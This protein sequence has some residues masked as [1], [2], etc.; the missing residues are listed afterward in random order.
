MKQNTKIG[1]ILVTGGAGFVGSHLI[2]KLLNETNTSMIYIIDN[3]VRTN[4]LRNIQHLLDDPK[5][6][7]RLKFINADVSTF[8]F[9]SVIDPFQIS[10]VFHLSATRI[11]R[12][13]EFNA[14]GHKYIADAGFNL[15]NWISKYS[16]IKL[17]FASSASVYQSP[18]RFPIEETD[19]CNP[20]TIY[21]AGKFY[22]EN[23]IKS[24]NLLYGMDYT[25]N[26]FFSV[27]GPRMDNIGPYTEVIFNWLNSVKKGNTTITVNGDPE[28]K[29][30]DL[31][32]IDDVID[33]IMLS[34]FNSN[35]STFNVSSE[36]GVSLMSLINTIQNVTGKNLK[37]NIVP[38]TRKDIELKRVGSIEKLKLIGWQ[39]KIDLAS[40]ILKTFEWVLKTNNI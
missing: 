31:V 21:G 17:F 33:A 23:I 38:D 29:I 30:L 14:E 12:C 8:D 19:A 16:N 28:Q 10:H 39:P 11:N 18:K 15:I 35:N 9:E 20:H 32:Y 7:S 22:T 26:R 13:N 37:L 6:S 40:G 1:K 25:I 34:T 27:Y 3:L 5:T 4:N 36:C 24:Y 2:E